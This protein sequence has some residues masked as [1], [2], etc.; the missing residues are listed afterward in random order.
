MSTIAQ[1][2]FASQVLVIPDPFVPN[3]QILFQRSQ[4]TGMTGMFYSTN[5]GKSY[6]PLLPVPG[7]RD[8]MGAVPTL[9]ADGSVSWQQPPVVSVLSANITDATAA[10]QALLTQN[11]LQAVQ[12]PPFQLQANIGTP[13]EPVWQPIW[14]FP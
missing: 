3:N 8:R 1:Q 7:C 10:G 5:G 12:G 13:T 6:V 4:T 2:E 11:L 9:N 14:Q